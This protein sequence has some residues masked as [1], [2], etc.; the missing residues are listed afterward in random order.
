MAESFG[1]QGRGAFYEQAGAIRDVVQN[2]LLQVLAILTMEPPSGNNAEAIRDEKVKVFRAIPP[3]APADVVRGQFRGYRNET[4][5][6]PDSQV[7]TFVALRLAIE[8]WRWKGVPVYIRAGKCLPVTCTE[9]YVELESPPAVFLSHLQP[10]YLR[11]RLNPEVTIARGAMTKTPGEAMRGQ[12][13]ELVV[14]HSPDGEEMDAYER[15]LGDAMHGDATLFAREDTVEAAW[16][17]VDPVV[18]GGAGIEYYEPNTWGPSGASSKV[19]P[20]G[21]WHDPQVS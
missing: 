17:I 13:V 14:S 6:A 1:V 8:S 12:T 21:G 11:F 5:V 7:E 9:V 15:L 2:H 10:N 16:R 18:G 3:L 4:G 20:P 19:V